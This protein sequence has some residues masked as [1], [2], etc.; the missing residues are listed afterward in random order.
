MARMSEEMYEFIQDINE[1]S[2][3][4]R[5]ARN[6]KTHRGKGGKVILPSDHYSKKQL[7]AM[8][9]EVKTYRLG[10]PMSWKELRAMPED[11]QRMYIKE[12][13]KKFNVPDI[14]LAQL[15]NVKPD[16]MDI[17]IH[18]LG[19]PVNYSVNEYG[20]D[21]YDTDDHEKFVSWWTNAKEDSNE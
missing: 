16:K 9:G 4:A 8:N 15:F 21:W 11:L 5:S 7:E 6:R 19:L 13:R 3:T 18:N 14:E 10:E 2:F 12:L 1:K 17:Y 20:L